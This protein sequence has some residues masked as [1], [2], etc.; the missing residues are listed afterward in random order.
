M[1][2]SRHFDFS[3]SHPAWLQR[4]NQLGRSLL[5][6]GA[7]GI[8]LDADSMLAEATR[9]TGLTDFGGDA[10]L[11]PLSVLCGSLEQEAQLNLMGRLLARSDVVNL[12]E[13]RLQVTETYR[14]HPEIGDE[15][16]VGPMFIIGLPRSGT[17]ILHEL[18][19]CDPAHRVPLSWE[20]RF[21]CP[22][23]EAASY[24]TDPRIAMAEEVFTF[25]NELVPEYRTMHEMG[26]RIPCECVWLT[27]P[28]FVSEEFLGRQ[29]IPSFGAWY[30]QADLRPAYAYH[31]KM[32]K[33]LQWK[34]SR[35]RWMLK[36][37]SH[38]AG[39]AVLLEHYPDAR[40]IQTHRDPLKSMGSTAS[41]LAAL[42][43]MRSDEIDPAV[44]QAGFGGEG[45]ANRLEQAMR[46][47]D[48]DGIDGRQFFDVRYVDLLSD[49]FEV[50]GRLYSHFELDFTSETETRMREYLA[51]KPQARH[52]AHTPHIVRVRVVM[53]G[54]LGHHD[55]ARQR[56]PDQA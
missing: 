9:N 35:E 38:M 37:P 54:L 26:A 28:S 36:A 34:N 1:T 3:D 12:L 46:V 16:V 50:I 55:P 42:H 27:A 21:P 49:P 45:M 13:N 23:P 15:R 25:W 39:L 43:S 41:V 19:A 29:K 32:L 18:L 56:R 51:A 11:E 17:S 24:E 22:P 31:H 52:G 10:F 53:P 8:P 33:L 44:I 7:M 40:I 20:A 4:F 5:A 48:A 2:E 14:L 47:Q 6:S 30:A